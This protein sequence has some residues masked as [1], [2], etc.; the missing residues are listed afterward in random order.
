MLQVISVTFID[1]FIV[2]TFVQGDHGRKS[3]DTSLKGNCGKAPVVP[4]QVNVI[5]SKKL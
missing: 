1:L 2:S 5:F 3:P 4:H